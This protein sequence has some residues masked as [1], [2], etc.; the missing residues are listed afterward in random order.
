MVNLLAVSEVFGD[1]FRTS[2]HPSCTH[3]APPLWKLSFEKPFS[4]IRGKY[5]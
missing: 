4:L 1:G 2:K 5:R 3:E